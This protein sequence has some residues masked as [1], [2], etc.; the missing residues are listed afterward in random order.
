MYCYYTV[1]SS[2]AVVFFPLLFGFKRKI[3]SWV[4]VPV[5]SYFFEYRLN[6][7]AYTI[8][9]Y[10]VSWK[11]KNQKFQRHFLAAA[12]LKGQHFVLLLFTIFKIKWKLNVEALSY[13]LI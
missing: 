9:F 8:H 3:E 7:E 10:A 2:S 12:V 1:G 11:T 4:E 13:N 5:K 6:L